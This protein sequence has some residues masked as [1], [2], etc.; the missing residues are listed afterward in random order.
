M[1]EECLEGEISRRRAG[2]DLSSHPPTFTKIVLAELGMFLLLYGTVSIGYRVS[3]SHVR[4]RLEGFFIFCRNFQGL[5]P[6]AFILGF[7]VT[8]VFTRWWN[9]CLSIPSLGRTILLIRDLDDRNDSEG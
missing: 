6:L 3:S 7:Y 2:A 1:A 5:I 8:Q 9:Q 4:D